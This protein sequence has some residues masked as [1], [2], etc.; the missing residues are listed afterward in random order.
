MPKHTTTSSFNK[1][2]AA[3][4]ACA[5]F[6]VATEWYIYANRPGI[7]KDFWS[8]F[9]I[10][11]RLLIDQPKDFDYLII[12]DSIQKTG[13]DPTRVAGDILCLGLP[14]GKP[15][16]LYL[17][18]KRYLSAH[19]PPKAVF[20]YVDPE[21]AYQSLDSILRYFVT[22]PEALSV[23]GDLTPRERQVFITRYWASLDMRIMRTLMRDE[24]HGSND[25]FVKDL[26]GNRGYMSAP[27]AENSLPEDSFNKNT[28]RVCDDI[29]VSAS[30]LKYLDKFMGLAR[31]SNVKVVFLGFVV[32]EQL[33]RILAENGFTGKYRRFYEGL[34][35][36]YPDAGFVDEPVAYLPNRFFGDYF[37]MNKKGVSLYTE[38][39]NDKVFAPFI[40][41]TPREG[42][43]EG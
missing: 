29:S 27:R 32:P 20:L 17:L 43:Q 19:K 25:L 39:F 41:V 12:G 34:K 21:N 4:I 30:D 11:E 37:H 7:I 8:K 33:Y 3:V 18:F 42:R 24:Y 10:N 1:A 14:G 9:V 13:I 23:W 15:M 31:G 36:R 28:P 26:I 2:L 6:V 40:Y 38:Y 35:S 5:V 22:V 16:G